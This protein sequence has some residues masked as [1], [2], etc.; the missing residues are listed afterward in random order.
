MKRVVDVSISLVALLALMPV[1]AIIALLIK[2]DSS[3][4]VF[5]LQER[6]GRSGKPFKIIK[7]RTMVVNAEDKLNALMR[8]NERDGPTFKMRDDPR[9][10]RI[11]RYLRRFA[12]DELPQ[13]ANVLIGQMSIVGPRPPTPKEVLN[14]SPWHMLRLEATPGIT[15]TWQ[16]SHREQSFDEWV[17][18]DLIYIMNQNLLYDLYLIIKTLKVFVVGH[19]DYAPVKHRN[20]VRGVVIKA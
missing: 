14:Y 12:L 18:M 8:L 13:F 20:A 19:P 7:F 5:F 6:V 3:G 4:P 15:C 2:L 17:Q 16:I 1:L 10:T 9:V 11:G